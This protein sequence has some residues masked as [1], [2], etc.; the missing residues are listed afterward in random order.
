MQTR[1][2][3][4]LVSRPASS[5]VTAILSIQL[6]ITHTYTLSRPRLVWWPVEVRPPA[7]AALPSDPQP[8]LRVIG[9][10]RIGRST[11]T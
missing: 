1:N 10:M 9:E 5:D 4:F 7:A 2:E 6:Y 8:M 3:S 11:P